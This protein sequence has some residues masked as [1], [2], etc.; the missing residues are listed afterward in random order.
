MHSTRPQAARSFIFKGIEHTN[1]MSLATALA[2]NWRE[3]LRI[4]I[5]EKLDGWVARAIGDE[6]RGNMITQAIAAGRVDAG[7][8]GDATL[9]RV[10]AALDPEG[11]LRLRHVA[12][13]K[14]G[15]GPLIAVAFLDDDRD[16]RQAMAEIL[17]EGLPMIGLSL[18]DPNDQTKR[19][20]AQSELHRHEDD[21]H[22]GDLGERL[23]EVVDDHLHRT[24]GGGGAA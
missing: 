6:R 18:V 16:T 8:G 10:L 15:L 12:V 24:E 21:E 2:E 4:V 11:P 5:D 3:A 20:L 1:A 17:M 13:M 19:R 7:P 14:D 23:A 9:A 22:V